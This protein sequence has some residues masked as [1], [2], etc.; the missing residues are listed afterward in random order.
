MQPGAWL[1]SANGMEPISKAKA[2]NSGSLALSVDSFASG[3]AFIPLASGSQVSLEL[4]ANPHKLMASCDN[5]QAI[6]LAPSKP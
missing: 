4:M 6:R 2:V 1:S 5:V 3:M